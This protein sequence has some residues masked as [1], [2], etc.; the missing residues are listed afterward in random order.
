M[1]ANSVSQIVSALNVIYSSVSNNAQRL[2][3]QKFLDQVKL[4]KDA[5]LF[6]YTLGTQYENDYILKHFGL[7][8]LEYSIRKNWAS[9]DIA[10]MNAVRKWIEELNSKVTSQDPRYIKEKLAY[11]WAEIAKRVWGE[12][13]KITS[14][15]KDEDTDN[16][17][18]P[19]ELDE[20]Q[21][22]YSWCDMDTNL[23]QMWQMNESTREVVLII[24]RTL[25]EDI[26][27]LDDLIAMKRMSVLQPLCIMI[28]CPVQL[29]MN[30]YKFDKSWILFK[31]SNQNGW[32]S[33]WVNELR[34]LLNT[35]P[36][37]PYLVRLLETLKTSLNWPISD[38]VL[39]SNIAQLLF[40]CLLTNNS[41][42]KVLALDSLHILYT[43]PYPDSGQLD[44]LLETYYDSVDLLSQ[45]YDNLGFDPK[46]GVDDEKYPI[47]K[48]LVD[49][50]VSLHGSF[51]ILDEEGDATNKI[52]NGVEILG[53][54][55]NLVLKI[56]SNPSLV[57]SGLTL[58][59]W[60][61][62]LRQD[63]KLAI[64]DQFN[65]FTRLLQLAADFLIYFEQIENHVSKEFV[66]VDFQSLSEYKSFCS[67]YRRSIRDIIRLISCVRLDDTYDWLNSRLN[68]YF[69]SSFGSEVLTNVFLDHQSEPY[70]SA[71][72]QLMIIECFINGCIRWKI[73]WMNKA[74]YEEKLA[75]ILSKVEVLSNQL[76]SLNLKEPMLLK[77]QVQN[78]A[79]FLTIL[80]DNALF[81]LL[82]RII[83]T[84]TLEYPDEAKL[85]REGDERA[86]SIR[87]LRYACGVE[88]NR[89]ALLMPESLSRIYND[90]ES[91]VARILPNLSRHEVI[92]FKAF[93]MIIVLKSSMENKEAKFSSIVDP[94][95]V[96]W[97]DENT[98]TG[99]R[100]LPWFME[101]V[102]IVQ[103]AKYF[104]QR[105]INENSDLLAINID[106]QGRQLKLDLS[107]RWS[108]LFPV[109]A[110][111]IFVHY[112]VEKLKTIEDYAMVQTLWKPRIVPVLPYILRL[113]FQ[114]QSYH[115]PENWKDLPVVVQSF[116]RYS[117]IE[118]F[119]EA[120]AS[121]KTKDEFID[122]HMQA[123][124]TVRDFAD[125][126][127]HIVRYTRE[128][129][130][131]IIATVSRLGTIIYEIDELPQLI[132]DSIFIKKPDS[133]TISPGVSK[134]AWKHIVNMA[135]RP[136]IK[137][138]PEELQ[139]KFCSKF[140]PQLFTYLDII[141]CDL[142]SVY[143]NDSDFKPTPSDNE[144]ITEEILENNLLRQF[145]AVVVRLLIDNVGQVGSTSQASKLRLSAH[146]QRLRGIIFG[147]KEIL[148]PYLRLVNHLMTFKDS[149]CSLNTALIL[150]GGLKENVGLHPQIDE[151]Y[152]MEIMP[153]IL[154]NILMD[155]AYKDSFYDALFIYT[156]LMNEVYKNYPNAISFLEE[157][158]L[159]YDIHGL[160][161]RLGEAP[162]YKEQRVIMLEYLDWVKTGNGKN[163]GAD[164]DNEES[165]KKKRQ[166][167]LKK[168]SE[169][170]M[171]KNKDEGDMM[172]D[173][174]VED[175][176]VASLFSH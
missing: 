88:L 79:L 36:D 118:R 81:T 102:G 164:E 115:D 18:A 65:I 11:L 7:Q 104:Q 112:S 24:F 158:S 46:E 47:V 151:Y 132:L 60:V 159:G 82:E 97:S 111:R 51:L 166:A 95:L 107:K 5:P 121:N 83:T 139:P 130:L 143:M 76:I 140:L 70:L 89:M 168:A 93:L 50:T 31:N 155:P 63:K 54:Y 162:H 157:L 27:L 66:D 126:V 134:H 101:R 114:L 74:D 2:E 37:S 84:A 169:R 100:D 144:E 106:E 153:N 68:V 39:E 41:K 73:W 10:K 113:L 40:R 17:I 56:T 109:R 165:R 3:A 131:A 23:M 145:T 147:D 167:I 55:L 25:F 171:K 58:E 91:V 92:S 33:V 57:V 1:D 61:S 26:F 136:L 15:E 19:A 75:V 21:L 86:D 72:S 160:I 30:K 90:L 52:P 45:V 174:T 20:N 34:D 127:G 44:K 137:N 96:A 120:G 148:L 29:F 135:L 42:S 53:K 175:G 129:V 64:L 8:L 176:A 133:N 67:V 124:N 38:I 77:K 161:K 122:E 94:E 69:S 87:S 43:R 105:N 142:W 99:L 103:I 49:M 138:C 28:I 152:T 156:W 119:W 116:V 170:L 16:G 71:L 117:T 98:V 9:Y 48:K 78:F 123:M 163:T 22:L 80:E 35:S 12:Y 172:N 62:L 154:K 173:P 59:M 128:V 149:K 32:F 108:C 85:E 141:L 4:H 13:L 110:T 150:K 146:Q 14:I 6:G 125:S